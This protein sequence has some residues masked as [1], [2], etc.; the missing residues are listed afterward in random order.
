MPRILTIQGLFCSCGTFTG[1]VC[2]RGIIK[3]FASCMC[4]P[5]LPPYLPQIC[6]LCVQAY[7]LTSAQEKSVYGHYRGFTVRGL[8]QGVYIKGF[9]WVF[10]LRGLYG[11]LSG[12]LGGGLDGFWQNACKALF[13]RCLRGVL[14]WEYAFFNTFF[15]QCVFS[16]IPINIF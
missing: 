10:M 14:F 6:I 1:R 12:G 9:I 4:V 7:I 15:M 11:G 13:Y 5:V 8:Y 16:K 3:H 2:F